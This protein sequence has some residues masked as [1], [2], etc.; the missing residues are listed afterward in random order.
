M[1]PTFIL[2]LITYACIAAL[3][4][5]AEP[6]SH[7]ETGISLPDTIA[8]FTRGDATKYEVAPG[9]TGVAIPYHAPEVEVTIFIRHIDPQKITSPASLIEENLAVVKQLEASGTYSN[10]KIFKSADDSGT[11][12][13]SKAAF[14]ADSEKGFL[15]SFIYATLKADYAIKAR[16]TTTNPKNESVPKFVAEFQKIVNEAKPKL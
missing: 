2:V 4:C 16:I 1:R 12:G 8:G 6:F 14:I 11:P 9:E 10:V 13:W 3:A 7:A 15:A 5:A